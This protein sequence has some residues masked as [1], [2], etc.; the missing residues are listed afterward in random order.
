MKKMNRRNFMGTSIRKAAGISMGMSMLSSTTGRVLGANERIQVALV[1][2]GGRGGLVMRQMVEC[3]AEITAL[4]DI[5]TESRDKTAKFLL[6]VQSR[7]PKMLRTMAETFDSKDVDAVIIATPDH[8]HSLG[9]I[10]ACQAGKDVYVEK[11]HSH[12]I[13][14]SRKLIEAARKYKRIVQVGT[15]NRSGAY[16]H[17]AVEYIKSG[18]L[19]GIHLVKV[20][21]LKPGNRNFSTVS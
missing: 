11:P 19:G 21:N 15:Q 3:G 14:E 7:K 6:E 9:T 12:N 8:W 18:K 16:N 1:G 5:H 4:C 17:K 13:W 20:Y 10:L 2:C